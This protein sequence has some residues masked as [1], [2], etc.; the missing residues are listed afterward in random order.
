MLY[1]LGIPL[2]VLSR[3]N[4]RKIHGSL[5]IAGEAHMDTSIFGDFDDFRDL[6]TCCIQNPAIRRLRGTS[7]APKLE[8]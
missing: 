1:E 8:L 6:I 2:P 5:I 3:R 7:R 4:A